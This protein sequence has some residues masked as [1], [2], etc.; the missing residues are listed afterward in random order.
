MKEHVNNS[1]IST[2]F[3]LAITDILGVLNMLEV[4]KHDSKNLDK[5]T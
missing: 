5:S 3:I 1:P 2:T 4:R